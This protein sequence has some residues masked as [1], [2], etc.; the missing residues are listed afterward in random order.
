MKLISWNVNGLRASLNKGFMDFFTAEQPDIC[1]IQET[2]MQ[3]EQVNFELDGYEMYWNSAEKKGYSGTAVF[4]RIKPQ[5]VMINL[6]QPEHGSEGRV[7][8]LEYEEFYLVNTYAPNSQRGLVRLDYRLQWQDDF[9]AHLISLD[10][11][12]PVIVCGDL[13]VA[14]QEIDLKN[15]KSN[16]KNAGFSPQEREK[17]TA[18]LESGF[19]DS[20]RYLHPDQTGAYTWWS[21]MFDARAKNVGWRIDYFLVSDRIKDQIQNATIYSQVLGSDHCPIGLEI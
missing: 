5:S 21:Y 16:H 11:K 10:T 19:T 3:P 8:T 4:S 18:L 15:P 1:C 6:D 2:K 9:H 20:F 12:K 14:H 17:M 13:N 7:I